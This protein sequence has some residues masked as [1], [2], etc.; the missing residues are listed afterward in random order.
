MRVNG[1]AGS[2]FGQTG[3]SMARPKRVATVTLNSGP[4]Y[5]RAEFAEGLD[6]CGWDVQYDQGHN[7][8]PED[9]V[10]MWNRHGHKDVVARRWEKAGG[11]AL[12]VENAWLSG[13]K[14]LKQGHAFAVSVGQHNGCGYWRVGAEDRIAKFGIETKPWRENGKHV[15][16]LPQ[17]GIG[18]TGVA[19]P[20]GWVD[21]VSRRLVEMTDRRIRVR[22]HPGL[23]KW[24][25]DESL[26]RDL[27]GA[28]CAVTWASGAALKA[29]CWGIPVFYDLVGWIGAAA[30]LSLK[31]AGAVENP[32]L[33]DRRPMLHALTWAQWT[34]EE[35]KSGEA[36]KWL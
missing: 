11:R 23:H 2:G 20:K 26:K 36:L 33:G 12:I 19:M 24:G 13:G 15:L 17:R 18:P 9:I 1:A 6:A 5:G 16:I 31:A 27:E 21:D 14:Y 10:V 4:H 34:R 29:I 25:S 35:V 28:W 30:A 3:D 32:F 8:R 7:P 22:A